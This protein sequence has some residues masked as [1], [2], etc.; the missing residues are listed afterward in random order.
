MVVDIKRCI[1]EKISIWCTSKEQANQIWIDFFE[2]KNKK[3]IY[4]LWNIGD[5]TGFE[6]CCYHDVYPCWQ[7][8]YNRTYFIDKYKASKCLDYNEVLLNKIIEIW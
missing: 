6:V 1:E 4:D 2:Y 8:G 5:E 7:S 3:P